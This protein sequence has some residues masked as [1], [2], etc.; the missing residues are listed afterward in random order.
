[1]SYPTLPVRLAT[2]AL[3]LPVAKQFAL[4]IS[5]IRHVGL[6]LVYHRV[7]PNGPMPHEVVPTLSSALFRR[8]L[9]ALA[10]LGDVVPASQLLEPPRPGQRPRFC[11]TFD[12]DH[13]GHVQHALPILNS[14]GVR[15]TFFLSGRNLHGLRPYWWTYLEESIRSKGLAFTGQTLGLPGKTPADL[16]SALEGTPLADRLHEVLP[17]SL[18]SPMVAA[19]VRRLSDAGMTIGFHTLHH[20]RVSD[21]SGSDLDRVMTEGL[22]E[23]ASAANAEVNLLAYPYGRANPA[24]ADAAERAGFRAAF[25]SGGHPIGPR[26]NPFLLGRWDPGQLSADRLATA[27]TLRLLRMQTPP[28]LSPR[29]TQ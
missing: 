14:L 9:E 3:R 19:D 26:S 16:A 8:Q 29:Q 1:M 22:G 25:A 15:A 10:R 18:E 6:V 20:T 2:T 13:V 11:V 7:G 21:L 4:R 27:V 5:A 28:R 17:T 24:A 23:V 12:D